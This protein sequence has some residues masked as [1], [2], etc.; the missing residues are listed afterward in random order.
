MSL[1]RQMRGGKDYDAEWRTRMRGEG[2]IA[3][4]MAQRF[5][6]ARRRLGLDK[7]MPELDLSRFRPPTRAGD[8]GDLFAGLD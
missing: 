3:D 8:Q 4:L 7:A 6:A 1:V 5:N 2:P